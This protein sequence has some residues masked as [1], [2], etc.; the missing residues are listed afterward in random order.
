MLASLTLMAALAGFIQSPAVDELTSLARVGPE[1]VL[2][3]RAR[4]RPND[5]RDALRRLFIQ[6]A[7]DPSDTIPL[8]IS[9]RLVQ[10][11]TLAWRDSF[12]LRQVAW[13]A[14]RSPSER[15]SK[16]RGDSLRRA[17]NDA[18]SRVG[19]QAALLDWR[20]GLARYQH[21]AD[22]AGTAATPFA[23][24]SWP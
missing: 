11:Y 12:L 8:I 22:S 3:A 23:P 15:R 5:V 20:E 19:V 7:N 21:L 2:A 14:A 10:A 1:S 6:A 17:G 9:G 13:F 18:L 4:D 16:V 24:S